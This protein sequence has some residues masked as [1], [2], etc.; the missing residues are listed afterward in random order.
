[1]SEKIE[2]RMELSP[3]AAQ[4]LKAVEENYLRRGG[5]AWECAQEWEEQFTVEEIDELSSAIEEGLHEI[6]PGLTR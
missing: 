3:R 6:Q 1:M 5:P 2:L 4:L